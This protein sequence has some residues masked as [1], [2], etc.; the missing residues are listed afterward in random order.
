MDLS[1][2]KTDPKMEDGVWIDYAEGVSF[3]VASMARKAYNKA[4]AKHRSKVPAHK[5]RDPQVGEKI[6]MAAMADACLNDWK[7][8]TED[9]QPFPCTAENKAKVLAIPA[10]REWI[11]GQAADLTNFQAEAEAQ[12]AEDLKSGPEVA[13]GE[14]A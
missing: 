4:V 7:G 5:L 9:G 2:F 14:S 11:A 13:S 1:E 6:V 3:N 12:D 8:L 10:L